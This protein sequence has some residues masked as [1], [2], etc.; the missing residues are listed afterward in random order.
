MASSTNKLKKSEKE[1]SSCIYR[2]VHKPNVWIDALLTS[3]FFMEVM[4]I[5]YFF[6][7]DTTTLMALGTLVIIAAVCIKA[8]KMIF[9]VG[10]FYFS[11][12]CL[13][14]LGHPL[15]KKTTMKKFED[16]SWQLVIHV[17]MAI[18][19]YYILNHETWWDEPL[20]SK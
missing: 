12:V 17:I 6:R 16:Q 4:A 14:H 8:T 1:D 10:G 13:R 18:M 2:G 7:E 5:I 11:K 15:R 9:S 19:E 20:T 3:I